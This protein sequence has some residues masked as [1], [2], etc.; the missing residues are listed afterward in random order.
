MRFLWLVPALPVHLLVFP[1]AFVMFFLGLGVGLA[2]FPPLG[3]L[4]WAV[5]LAIAGLNM[6]W[7]FRL[8][9]QCRQGNMPAGNLQALRWWIL[10]SWR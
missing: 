4:I 6:L 8:W 9:R 5:A 3:M 7:L 10:R 1:L 2:I